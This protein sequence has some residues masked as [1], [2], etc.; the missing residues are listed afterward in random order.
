VAFPL[1]AVHV[2]KGVEPAALLLHGCVPKSERAMEKLTAWARRS[3]FTVAQRFD[4]MRRHQGRSEL[5][6]IA[7]VPVITAA[8][9]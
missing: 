4:E 3:L 1:R 9:R 6:E 7:G 2:A 5:S 8:A